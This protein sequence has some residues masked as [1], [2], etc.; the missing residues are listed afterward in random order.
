MKFGACECVEFNAVNREYIV[1]SKCTFVDVHLG[2][3]LRLPR[4]A[5]PHLVHLSHGALHGPVT[6]E[7]EAAP[8]AAPTLGARLGLPS[9]LAIG[10]GR[11]RAPPRGA[12][13]GACTLGAPAVPPLGTAPNTAPLVACANG[14][15][16]TRRPVADRVQPV[17][18]RFAS[19]QPRTC[20]D[21]GMAPH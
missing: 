4:A 10:A 7:L 2:L 20:E 12:V 18:G 11:L 16:A 17:V 8:G 9:S 1:V 15:L 5:R 13:V 6:P 14:P 3:R 21:E 19:H